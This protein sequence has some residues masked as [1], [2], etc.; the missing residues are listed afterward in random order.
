[1]DFVGAKSAEF[2]VKAIKQKC[3]LC[4]MACYLQSD[5]GHVLNQPPN[6]PFY[7][8]KDELLNQAKRQLENKNVKV[9]LPKCGVLPA[10]WQCLEKAHGN[11]YRKRAEDGNV[12]AK[13]TAIWNLDCDQFLVVLIVGCF[14]L[15]FICNHQKYLEN[16]FFTYKTHHVDAVSRSSFMLSV[17][18][19]KQHIAVGKVFLWWSLAKC[20]EGAM[21][22]SCPSLASP[23][24]PSSMS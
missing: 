21:R 19:K 3:K 16:I 9:L 12:T 10:C 14:R 2:D 11:I 8:L 17:A 6:Y 7:Q 4:T 13:C 5:W 22:S 23:T 20:S 24:T 1:V 18:Q 15:Y